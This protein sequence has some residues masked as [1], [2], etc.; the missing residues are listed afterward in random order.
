MTGLG[1]SLL[2]VEDAELLTGQARFI[3]DLPRPEGCIDLRFVRSFEAHAVLGN[4]EV[5]AARAMPGVTAVLRARDLPDLPDVPASPGSAVPPSMVRPALARDRVR[6]VGEAYAAV[7]A[8]TMAQA[9]DAAERVVPS[10]VPLPA[11]IG[12][13]GALAEGAQRIFDDHPNLV[14]ERVIGATDLPSLNSAPIRFQLEVRHGR[15]APASIEPRGIMV[16]P[17]RGGRIAIWCSH[18]APHRLKQ[19]L[20]EAF[21]LEPDLLHVIVPAVGGAFGGK[22]ATFPEYVVAMHAARSLGRP[23]RWLEDRSESLVSATHGRG[24]VHR[25]DVAADLGGRLLALGAQ[26]DLD[27]GAY[28]HTGMAVVAATALMMSG[29]YRIPELSVVTRVVLTNATPVAPY[30]GAGRPEAALSLERAMDELARRAGLDPVEVRMKNFIGPDAFPYDSPTGARYDSGRYAQ[31]L[32]RALDVGDYHGVR[33]EQQDRRRSG[34]RAP[35][36]GVGLASY[37][38]RSGGPV[39]S[40]EHGA[41]EVGDDGSVVARSGSSS[42]GQG[43]ATALSQIVAAAFGVDPSRIVVVAGDTD[44][45][46]EGTGTFA[47]RSIQIG[48]SALHL[49]AEQVVETARHAAANHLEVDPLDLVFASGSFE[50]VGAAHRSV[51]LWQLVATGVQLS[52]SVTFASPQAFPFGAHMAVVEI[53][54]DTGLVFLRTVVGVDDCGRMVNPMLVEGQA[55]GSMVQGIGQALYESVI[56]QEDGQPLSTSFLTYSIPTAAD[57]PGLVTETIE[58]SNPNVPIGAKG[59]GESGCIGTPAAIMNAVVD[60]LEGYDTSAITMPLTPETIL[61]VLAQGKADPPS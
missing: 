25:L 26:V 40:T 59:A 35:L 41:V 10:F 12:I 46:Q 19:Q 51:S 8:E 45:V 48:G 31:A 15:V 21:N 53:D 58:T 20:A 23:V 49:A 22:S 27:V 56:Y 57:L 1:E 43:H 38:E 17:E 39:G 34:E 3:A 7:L 47:S 32:E 30:R 60:A 37:V 4:V 52:A 2:R 6:F 11:V 54:P 50:V 29:P 13:E 18:Q 24:Q 61:E 55:L 44:E 36:L 42:Q 5:E 9:E 28:P 16:V 14:D 33:T